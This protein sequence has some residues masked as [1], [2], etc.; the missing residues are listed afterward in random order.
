VA[1]LG[2]LERLFRID[3]NLADQYSWYAPRRLKIY[4]IFSGGAAW[5]QRSPPNQMQD[6]EF[7]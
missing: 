6:S 3:P 4:E 5:H 1:L 7:K 2:A